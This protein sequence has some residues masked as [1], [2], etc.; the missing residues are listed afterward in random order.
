MSVVEATNSGVYRAFFLRRWGL[1]GL[2]AAGLLLA[3]PLPLARAE[4]L[5]REGAHSLVVVGAAPGFGSYKGKFG[6]WFELFVGHDFRL[7]ETLAIRAELSGLFASYS[8]SDSYQ[9]V[10]ADDIEFTDK[11]Q[12]FGGIARGLLDV[13]LSPRWSLRGGPL[14]GFAHASLDS[15][16]C[17]SASLNSTFIGLSA[18]SALRL[19]A[20]RQFEFGVLAD[21][22][23]FPLLRCAKTQPL[24]SV[25]RRDEFGFDDP[26]IAVTARFGYHW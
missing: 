10:G 9:V 1:A 6:P 2:A 12:T 20:E 26:T 25:H 24:P 16:L 4:G 19:G 8:D 7:T 15:T 3:W 13:G 11:V 22:I 21:F 18:G 17:G 14:V 23:G 5:D